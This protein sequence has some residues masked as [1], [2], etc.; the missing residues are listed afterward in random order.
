VPR[1][2]RKKPEEE[3]QITAWPSSAP[4]DIGSIA[5]AGYELSMD[6]EELGSRFLSDA[7][8]QGHSQRPIWY[9][10]YED[11]PFDPQL[12]KD[13]LRSLGLSS[14]RKRVSGR[15]P[16]MAGDAPRRRSM[17]LPPLPE[18]FQEYI[19]ES[20]EIDLTEENIREASLLD[21][22]GEEAGEIESPFVRT[23]DTHTHGKR[24]GG[25]APS[26]RPARSKG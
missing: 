18:E 11:V 4:E 26:M 9:D 2:K 15:P 20:G 21:H 12:G 24:R 19:T 13:L 7:V 14:A 5:P 23:D 25:H 1:A 17:S 8:E 3:E 16:A 6:C 10:E 22:E